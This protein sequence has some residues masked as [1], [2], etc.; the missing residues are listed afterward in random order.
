MSNGHAY[1]TRAHL[2][3]RQ[4]DT[5]DLCFSSPLT[6]ARARRPLAFRPPNNLATRIIPVRIVATSH[7]FGLCCG[8]TLLPF[9]IFEC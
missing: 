3:S 7:G 1:Q 8:H 5:V 6:Q 2:T 4:V 9:F